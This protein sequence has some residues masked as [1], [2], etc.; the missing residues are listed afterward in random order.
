MSRSAWKDI[1]WWVGLY[2]WI[3]VGAVVYG[4]AAAH[5]P[6]LI[7][8]PWSTCRVSG[9]GCGCVLVMHLFEVPL[10]TFNA[11]VAWYGLKRFSPETLPRF[12]SLVGFAVTANLVFFV[13]EIG[14]LIDS[15]RLEVPAWEIVLLS[16][17]AIML[18]SGAGLG[19]FLKQKMTVDSISISDRPPR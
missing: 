2:S 10:V 9:S 14:L 12:R 3:T 7:G 19:I 17:I 16:T 6:F 18:V 8:H 13:F 1:Q 11:L 5:A 4:V 15:L